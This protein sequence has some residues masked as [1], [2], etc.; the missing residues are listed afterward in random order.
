MRHKLAVE[1]AIDRLAARLNDAQI[2]YALVGAMAMAAHGHYRFTTDID[3]LTTKEGLARIHNTLAGLGY[4]P[5]FQGATKSLRDAVKNVNVDFITTG[6]YPGDGLPKQVAF[7]DPAEVAVEIS[8]VKVISL[9]KLI[10]LKLA[11]GLA[12]PKNRAKDLVDV[13]ELINRLK[14]PRTLGETLDAS[15][16]DEFYSMWDAARD[17]YDPSAG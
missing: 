12:S 9:P 1:E 10:E 7:P 14:P 2:P 6:E 16:R 4:V 13:Q 3:V 15:V 5:A 11:S 8:G 17:A